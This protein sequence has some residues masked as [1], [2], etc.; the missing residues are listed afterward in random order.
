MPR[1]RHPDAHAEFGRLMALPANDP[2]RPK[3]SDRVALSGPRL[4]ARARKFCTLAR[5]FDPNPT[6]INKRP[7]PSYAEWLRKASAPRPML[8]GP[9]PVPDP[10]PDPERYIRTFNTLH[11]LKA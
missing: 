7:L 8:L 11:N 4:A 3:L 5:E 1:K 2:E 10:T 6:P 9:W